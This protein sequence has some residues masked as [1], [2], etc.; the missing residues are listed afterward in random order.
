VPVAMAHTIAGKIPGGKI[1][2][3]E[4]EAHLEVF[5]HLEE[6]LKQLIME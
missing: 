5:P 4:S 6:I 1:T 2:I 3:F